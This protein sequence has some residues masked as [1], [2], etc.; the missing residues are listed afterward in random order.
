[1]DAGVLETI[2]IPERALKCLFR[3]IR[4]TVSAHKRAATVSLRIV[5]REPEALDVSIQTPWSW[6]SE[7]SSKRREKERSNVGADQLNVLAIVEN[8]EI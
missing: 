5:R 1:M 7:W 3:P 8:I 6:Q 2:V 4:N